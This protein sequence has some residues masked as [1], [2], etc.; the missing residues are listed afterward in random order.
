M[1]K[2]SKKSQAALEFL[3][4]YGWAFLV[5][6]IMIGTL[7][8]FGILSPSTLLPDRCNLGSDIGCVNY[9]IA[10][11]GVN[12]KLKNNVGEPI[13]ISDIS[14]STEK[15]PLSCNSAAVGTGW[16]SGELKDISVVCD[17]TNAG[18]T[19]GQKGKL[20]LKISYYPSKS[21]SSYAR[22]VSGDLYS[23]VQ[24]STVSGGGAAAGCTLTALPSS[25]S[26]PLSGT[27]SWTASNSPTLCTASGG[28][29]GSK[30]VIGGSE[31]YVDISST[32][33][34]DLDCTN[35]FGAVR[36]S[37][38]VTIIGA[39][40]DITPPIVT[41]MAPASGPLPP[42]TVTVTA[43]ASD[44]V[45]VASVQFLVDGSPI[46]T[47]NTPS[48]D[49]SVNWD[50]TTASNGNHDLSAIA[51]DTSSNQATSPPIT[52][53]VSNAVSF[54]FS[55]SNSG[56]ITATQASSGSNTIT[57]TLV[58][59]TT[60]AVTFSAS[61]LPAGATALFNPTSCS[62]TC[63]P[64][65]TLTIQ[66][67]ASTPTGVYTITVTGT[68]GSLPP[69]TTNFLLTVLPSGLVGN[70]KFDEGSG[71]SAADSS[72][73]GNTGTLL[74]NGIGPTW[75]TGKINGALNFDGVDDQVT[76][77]N[78]FNNPQVFTIS[79]WFK[80]TSASGKK[81]VGFENLQTGTNSGSWDRHIY[82]GTDG[83]I[84]F[85]WYSGA[86]NIVS[87]TNTL[88][89]GQWHHAVGTHDA[90][91]VG[92]LY[93][94]GVLQGTLTNPAEVYNGYWRIGGYK[95]EFWTSG[96]DGYFTGEIDEARIYNVALSAQEVSDLFNSAGPSF[97]FS[98]SNTGD[99]L[100][101]QGS[102]VTN[103]ITATLV[104]GTTQA[105]TFSASGLP[106]GATALFNPTSCS[107][108]CT[109]TTTLTIQTAAS[110]PTGV[111]TITVTGT[112]GSLPP[113]TTNFL[114]TVLPS[115]LVGNWKFDEGSGNAASDPSGNGNIGTLSP[116]GSGPTWTTGKVGGALRFDGS[117]DYVNVPDT[118]ASS[119]DVTTVTIAAWINPSNYDVINDRG[120]IVNKE[121]TWEI[122]LE[123]LTGKLQG[124]A[125]PPSCWR[126]AGTLVIPLNAWTHVAVVFD[127]T[128]ELH[129]VNG[130]LIE[131]FS[132]PGSLAIN[133]EDLRIAARGGDAPVS[134]FFNGAIDDVRIYNRALTLSEVQ[135]L[136]N[137]G[138]GQP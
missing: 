86:L 36:C 78:L 45:A 90:S 127:G 94:D 102:F 75:T 81:I 20:N 29:S 38:T 121:D 51:T 16:K 116:S 115:G 89:D 124:A 27:L 55:L 122:G 14:V 70:W 33:T 126:W 104:S 52:V 84:K 69:R 79:V 106:A 125:S 48:P 112:A 109:P 82:M 37:A 6:L 18:I 114:L 136:Y 100:V 10:D 110:T 117:N 17:F 60:Q 64:T 3:T 137:G 31:P 7:A 30:P 138:A 34:Y 74:P 12:L 11:N 43:D 131:S 4:T 87:S 88:N 61:G 63:T 77:S 108:T 22:D 35:S 134:S 46:G 71:T 47:D 13:I 111:Y 15:T 39:G 8:Y 92:K 32:T 53:T 65:T 107:P 103:D 95:L 130:N 85:G 42:G 118:G 24:S 128:D 50:T 132:C 133:N 2:V 68:A 25:G 91:N 97:D 80:T 19:A 28:W 1:E 120:I 93:I 54:D 99:K 101:T 26:A 98:L 105:V 21:G 67:A 9:F 40:G 5:I 49:Y 58:S 119:L 73:N 135:T 129:Y 56:G 23:T 96:S 113:R 59:G 66:T 44:N 76:T 57:A 41:I 62:P 83:R 123:D 72:G